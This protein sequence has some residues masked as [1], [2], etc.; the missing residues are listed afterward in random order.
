MRISTAQLFR[1]G[2]GGIQAQQAKVARTQRQISSGQRILTPA[3]DPSGAK[4]LLDLDHA[5]A[6][7]LTRRF[8]TNADLATNRLGLEES[9]LAGAVNVVQRVRELTI[10]AGNAVLT[11]G[12]RRGL[13]AEIDARL[14]E[15]IGLAN[16]KDANGEF[17]FAGVSSQ[18]RPFVRAPGGTVAYNGDQGQRSVWV[19]PG[20]AVEVGDSGSAVFVA[21]RNGNG[22]FVTRQSTANTGTGVIDAGSVIDPSAWVPDAYTLSFPTAATF[23]VRDGG[24]GLVLGGAYADGAAVGF[25]GIEVSLRGQPGAG[26]SFAIETS[27]NQA[28][29]TTI[30]NLSSALQASV[31]D[32]TDSAALD[33]ALN[34]ALTDLDRGMDNLLRIRAEVGARLNAVESEHTVNEQFEVHLQQVTS[35]L[36]D[37]DYAEAV[38]RLAQQAT[39]L[40]AAQAAFVRVQGLSLFNF[41]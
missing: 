3:D 7:T 41:I 26:D 8:I 34:R 29:F 22:T 13:A 38:S 27:A 23:E 30:G 21:I 9:T 10:Q 36:Q 6:L 28:L 40:E 16:T 5:L 4:Q 18:T 32:G 39:T 2:I 14:D 17:L 15:L 20:Y 37:L 1:Q 24:G 19:A 35:Q 25:N 31:V 11:D 12:D 33:N